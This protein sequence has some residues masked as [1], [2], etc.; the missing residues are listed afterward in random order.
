MGYWSIG[1]F[2][3]FGVLRVLVGF[4]IFGV[5]MGFGILW[6]LWIPVGFEILRFLVGFVWVCKFYQYPRVAGEVGVSKFQKVW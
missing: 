1:A 3:I 2:G 4:G 5:L 6:D